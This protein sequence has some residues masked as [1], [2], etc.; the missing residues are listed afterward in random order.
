MAEGYTAI[1][2]ARALRPDLVFRE[3][4]VDLEP[5]F[6]ALRGQTPLGRLAR[7]FYEAGYFAHGWNSQSGEGNVRIE[8]RE[9]RMWDA[10]RVMRCHANTL[11][12]SKLSLLN[13]RFP[14]MPSPPTGAL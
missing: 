4:K 5:V 8:N 7:V 9:L 6:D 12:H 3:R 14:F 13:S 10:D 11:P 1:H 2:A